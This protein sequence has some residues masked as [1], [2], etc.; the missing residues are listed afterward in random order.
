MSSYY[1]VMRRST[2]VK[3]E[4]YFITWLPKGGDLFNES[5]RSLE[6]PVAPLSSTHNVIILL[7]VAKH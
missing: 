5:R 7:V 4:I 6:I 1:S 3:A 2:R